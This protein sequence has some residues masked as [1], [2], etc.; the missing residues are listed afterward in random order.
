M[1]KNDKPNF[2]LVVGMGIVIALALGAGAIGYVIG[3]AR[4]PRKTSSTAPSYTYMHMQGAPV[5]IN[6]QTG[7]SHILLP[8]KGWVLLA[9]GDR[10]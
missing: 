3:Q 2:G 1:N 6:T 9:P 10:P 5:R 7:E 8:E 4:A